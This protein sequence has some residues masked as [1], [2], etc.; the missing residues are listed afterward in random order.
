MDEEIIK[1]GR[2]AKTVIDLPEFKL[3]SEAVKLDIFNQFSKTNPNDDETRKSLH[4]VIYG[5][6]LL[7]KKLS[8]Y[9]QQGAYEEAQREQNK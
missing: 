8:G 5:L 1:R 9:V 6:Q 2:N 4:Q 3:V 7:E